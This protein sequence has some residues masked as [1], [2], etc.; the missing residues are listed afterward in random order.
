MAKN[1]AWI[2]YTKY[3]EIV[4][5]SLIVSPKRPVNGV[6]Y[7]V[8]TDICCDTEPPFGL[9]SSKQKAFVKYDA[10]GNIVPGSLVLTDGRLPRP[11]IWK[12]VY[13]NICCSSNNNR[14]FWY[15][16]DNLA[17]P[18]NGF[19]N[20]PNLCIS[21]TLLDP[22]Q[23]GLINPGA[24]CVPAENYNQLY[25]NL[26]DSNGVYSNELASM[27]GNSGTLTFTQG[28]NSVTYSFTAASFI[29]NPY[30][31]SNTI[32]FDTTLGSVPNS[33]VVTSPATSDFNTV[34]PITIQVS[35][36][37]E[38]LN[39]VTICGVTWSG[40]N[41]DVTTFRNGD[42][43][44]LITDLTAWAAAGLAGQPAYTYVNGDSNNTATYGL[45][46]NW[47]AAND[48]RGIGPTGWHV[49]NDTEWD[50]LRACLGGAALA[51]G[52]M[53]EIGLAH[54]LTPNTGATNSS[55]F[56][57]LPAGTLESAVFGSLTS[58]AY[59]WSSTTNPTFSFQ[60]S[61]YYNDYAGTQTSK[62]AS[63]YK[64]NG[65]SLRLVKD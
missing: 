11:G 57:S 19:F 8:V 43:I 36:T 31:I 10:S 34:D 7:E 55:G 13:I 61:R 50:A 39:P 47:Y 60:A 44:P 6:W 2:Q 28:S 49:P 9:I 51:G 32:A 63:Y 40:K 56:T 16:T 48:P 26:I 4:P 64:G 62:V 52:A 20:I 14:S 59:Y 22:N 3:G 38:P 46:Y 45:L 35:I 18:E 53:K 17:P 27:A 33:F 12:E 5:G 37:F 54:W 42:P 24:S 58:G 30:A 15:I 21:E 25:I 41:L 1:K 65:V 29:L 23:A